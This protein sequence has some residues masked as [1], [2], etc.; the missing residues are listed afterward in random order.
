MQASPNDSA[1]RRRLIAV[2]KMKGA[3]HRKRADWIGVDWLRPAERMRP[4]RLEV[5]K[6]ERD[7]RQALNM[8]GAFAVGFAVASVVW[9]S[10]LGVIR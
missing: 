8:L 6:P 5:P 1:P 4:Q 10:I 3:S 9:V 2:G 7:H